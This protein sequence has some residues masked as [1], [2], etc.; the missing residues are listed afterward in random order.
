MQICAQDA[1]KRM[2]VFALS[3]CC[4]V[5]RIHEKENKEGFCC[6]VCLVKDCR[7]LFSCP[8]ENCCQ[9]RRRIFSGCLRNEKEQDLKK[10]LQKESSHRKRQECTCILEGP[11][12]K[13]REWLQYDYSNYTMP[14][15]MLLDSL[16]WW[17]WWC[18]SCCVLYC[19]SLSRRRHSLSFLFHVLALSLNSGEEEWSKNL[20]VLRRCPFGLPAFL[21]HGLCYREWLVLLPSHELHLIHFFIIL[22]L[23]L[24]L[25]YFS[26]L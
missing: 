4:I 25:L 11:A 3:Y 26:S 13:V 2:H 23:C 12:E 9:M 20:L 24:R 16:G 5:V 6:D 14:S 19:L 10:C 8:V 1:W 18:A 22:L 15:F 21:Y 17:S 7:S